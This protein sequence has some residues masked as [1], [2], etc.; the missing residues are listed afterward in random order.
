MLSKFLSRSIIK[1]AIHAIVHYA[2]IEEQ[3]TEENSQINFMLL[4][5]IEVKKNNNNGKENWWYWCYN[6]NINDKGRSIYVG[7]GT[8]L[9]FSMR[10]WYKIDVD[11]FPVH[12]GHL[13]AIIYNTLASNKVFNAWKEQSLSQSIFFF[14]LNPMYLYH[15]TYLLGTYII[16]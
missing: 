15:Y 2:E 12:N 10:R 13:Y 1:E 3:K 14:L 5:F 7:I 8:L 9:I 6:N 4:I 16:Y 11:Y